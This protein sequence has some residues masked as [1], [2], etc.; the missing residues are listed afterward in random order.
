[1]LEQVLRTVIPEQLRVF[2]KLTSGKDPYYFSRWDR[3]K[4]SGEP[5]LRYWFWSKDRSCK[6]HK[7]VFIDELGRLL[8]SAVDTGE[9]T[10]SA[11][12][13]YCPKTSSSGPCGFAVIIGV[14]EHLNIVRRAAPAVYDIIDL[15]RAQEMVEG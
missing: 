11:Y 4:A 1:M 15:D 8:G 10:R 13:R 12:K 2:S 6:R 3:D 14:L 7:R 9:I 5:I